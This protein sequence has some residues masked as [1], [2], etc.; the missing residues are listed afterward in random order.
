[1][2]GDLDTNRDT[3]IRIIK[4]EIGM[5][6]I[7]VTRF[8]TGYCHCVYYVKTKNGEFVLRITGKDA[9]NYYYGSIK[10]LSELDTLGIPVPK[11][12][13]HGQN[14]DVFF[15]LLSFIPGK[16]LG[17]I[18]YTLNDSQKRKIVR[19]LSVIQRKIANLPTSGRYGYLHS[20]NTD[21]FITWIEYIES[22]IAR[23]RKRIRKN[24][25]F[26]AD[27]CDCVTAAMD[28]QKEYL[29]K[30]QPTPFL[31]DITTK[32]VLIHE[33]KLSGI[34]DIDEI[35]CG[36]PLFVIG[37][38]NMALL[39]MQT[40]TKYID[41]WLDEMNADDVQRNAVVFYTL[42]FCVDFMGEQGMQFGND[43]VISYNQKTV[44]LLYSYYYELLG[45]LI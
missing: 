38:T 28:N 15:A 18:Y 22:C 45:K 27:I 13:S 39:F 40:D 33:G 8:T 16:D 31:D 19:E 11:I 25:I 21:S 3:A 10:W 34:V 43:K 5:K 37:L 23:A 4:Q 35:C 12:I 6:P 2:F 29:L 36:D 1:M 26:D 32:N 9:K 42:L 14:E 24:K 7:N 17:E 44:D 41:Y 30:V 20:E